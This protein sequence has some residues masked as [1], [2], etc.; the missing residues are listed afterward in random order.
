MVE[1]SD[2]RTLLLF[3]LLFIV[4]RKVRIHNT[5]ERAYILQERSLHA[6][7]EQSSIFKGKLS[8]L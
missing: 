1:F 5:F 7:M 3:Y 2:S 4:N 6:K 8:A